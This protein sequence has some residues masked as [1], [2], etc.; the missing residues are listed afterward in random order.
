MLPYVPI[1]P[2]LTIPHSAIQHSMRL[3]GPTLGHIVGFG[4]FIVILQVLQLFY[5][6]HLS[7]NGIGCF[8]LQLLL[9]PMVYE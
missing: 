2:Q 8:T 5:H 6:L 1:L 3:P 7:V 4:C 9:V